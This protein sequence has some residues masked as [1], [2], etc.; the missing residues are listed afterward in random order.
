MAA[1]QSETHGGQINGGPTNGDQ[2][3]DIYAGPTHEIHAG[4]INLIYGSLTQRHL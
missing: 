2:I 1:E 3:I 4:Q